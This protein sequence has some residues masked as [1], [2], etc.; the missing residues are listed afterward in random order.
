MSTSRRTIINRSC[1]WRSS[2]DL[3]RLHGARQDRIQAGGADILRQWRVHSQ[4]QPAKQVQPE[5]VPFLGVYMVDETT[6]P[7]GDANVGEVRFHSVATIGISVIVQNND[8]SAASAKLDQAWG[9]I[10]RLF[11]DP[12]VYNWKNVGKPNEVAIQSFDRGQ[13]THVYGDIGQ[14][15]AIPIA[16]LRY[17]LQCNLGVIDYEPTIVDDLEQFT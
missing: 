7:D 6:T 3:L 17:N 2:H 15:N 16:E 1:G 5:N 14:E 11:D 8:A 9:E 4:H 13:R 10:E 12:T